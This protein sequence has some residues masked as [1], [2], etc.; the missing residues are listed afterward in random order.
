MSFAPYVC[1][2]FSMLNESIYTV[3]LCC[4]GKEYEACDDISAT[5][6]EDTI[7]AYLQN[8]DDVPD[9]GLIEQEVQNLAPTCPMDYM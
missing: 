6:I 3:C 9:V 5:A 4:I 1:S 7:T 8:I 2:H